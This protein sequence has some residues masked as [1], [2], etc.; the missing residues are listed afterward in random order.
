MPLIDK[1]GFDKLAGQLDALR[2]VH[3]AR[4]GE[5]DL[6]GK[7]RVLALLAASTAFQS[8]SRSAN[9]RR[10]AFRQ[11]HFGMND[12]IL[13]G[14]I[15][16]AVEPLVVQPLGPAIGGGGHRAAPACAADDLTERWKIAMRQSIYAIKA[17]VGT[18]YKRALP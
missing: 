6:A 18:T 12:A 4:N 16:I 15:M 7:L 2:L 8:F 10:R 1:F 3:L 11:Q 13:V 14:E 9:S 17:H 5:L